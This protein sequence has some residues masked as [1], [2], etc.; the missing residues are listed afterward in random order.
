MSDTRSTSLSTL[1]SLFVVVVALTPIVS[2]AAG[3]CPAGMVPS[4]SVESSG[5]ASTFDLKGGAGVKCIKSGREGAKDVPVDSAG[6]ESGL[7]VSNPPPP[8][9]FYDLLR[10]VEDEPRWNCTLREGEKSPTSGVCRADRTVC[11]SGPSYSINSGEIFAVPG[12]GSRGNP[13]DVTY[14]SI[15]RD[16][17]T[18]TDSSNGFRFRPPL[19]SAPRGNAG[20][21]PAGESAPEPVVIIVTQSDFAKLPVKPSVASAGPERGWLPAGMVNVLHAESEAQTLQTEL[22]GT[23]VAVRAIPTSYHWD[24]GDGNMIT[25]S[26]PGKPYPSEEVSAKYSEEGWYDVTLT[27]TFAGQFSVDGGEW[28]DID[29]TIEVAS[30]PIALYSKSLESRLVNGDVPVDED[31]DPCVPER[32]PETEGP[33]DPNARHREI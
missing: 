8:P 3:E 21:A 15:T 28:Q 5:S 12:S 23:P 6:P 25:T 1:L 22:L 7:E 9:R 17:Q 13:G 32:S 27:T 11:N 30:E 4:V 16:T 31:E 29:G 24:L 2:Y 10:R 19:E 18:G 20:A 33:K 26:K 14:E